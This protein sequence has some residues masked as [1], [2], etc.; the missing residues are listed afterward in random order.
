LF[1]QAKLEF[2]ED[3]RLKIRTTEENSTEKGLERAVSDSN[4]E[5]KY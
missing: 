5:A 2:T 3:R 4:H 1:D